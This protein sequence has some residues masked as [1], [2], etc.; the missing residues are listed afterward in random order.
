M[1]DLRVAVA[2]ATCNGERYLRQQLD[3]IAANTRAPEEIV[4]TDDCSTDGTVGIAEAFARQAPCPVRIEQNPKRLGFNGNFQRAASLA[5]G[6]VLLFSDQDDVW[7]PDHIE[8]LA[9]PFESNRDVAVVVSNSLYVDADL[10]PTGR[11]LWTAERFHRG[12]LRRARSGWQYPGWVRHR[13]VAGHGMAVRADLRPVMLPVG[14]DWTYDHWLAL[15]AT[16]CGTLVIETRPLTLHRQ[17][18][19]QTLAHRGESLLEAYR[20]NR[21]L[22]ASHFSRRIARWTELRNRLAAHSSLLRDERVIDVI[23]ARIAFLDS[24]RTMRLYG[25]MNRF[26]R[27][28][29]ELLRGGYHRCGRGLLSYARDVAG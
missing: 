28:T 29:A 9:A 17:H 3:S 26:V 6:D 15:T 20:R 7:L 27:A 13:A 12:D 11:T 18:D 21:L 5:E 8:R 14:A 1:P 2:I 25:S 4:L 19:N 22:G 10:R 23:D 16:A 24:R